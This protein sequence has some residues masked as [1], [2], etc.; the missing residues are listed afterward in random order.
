[1]PNAL[2]IQGSDAIVAEVAGHAWAAWPD[3]PTAIAPARRYFAKFNPADLAAAKVS[4]IGLTDQVETFTRAKNQE[5]VGVFV[6]VQKLLADRADVAE[7]DRWVNFMAELLAFFSDNHRL[8]GLDDW[9]VEDAQYVLSQVWSQ[10]FLY[11][12]GIFAAALALTLRS[13]SQ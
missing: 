8:A 10:S 11:A 9:W 1:M 5:D 3:A 13:D 7:V 4:V 12:D 6:D 2:L